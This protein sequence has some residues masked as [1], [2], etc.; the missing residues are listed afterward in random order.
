MSS[1][2][3]GPP[4]ASKEEISKLTRISGKQG[5]TTD[6]RPSKG[7]LLIIAIKQ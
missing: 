4:P 1:A 7:K 2:G 3:D 5:K 6:D